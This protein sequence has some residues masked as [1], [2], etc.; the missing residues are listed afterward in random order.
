MRKD[1]KKNLRKPIVPTIGWVRGTKKQT[2]I[3]SLGAK[4][5]VRKKEKTNTAELKKMV[6]HF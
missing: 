4:D 1:K 5:I 6:W 2:S 3:P